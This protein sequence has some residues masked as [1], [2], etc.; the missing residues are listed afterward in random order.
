[1]SRTDA[2]HSQGVQKGDHNKQTNFYLAPSL[3]GGSRVYVSSDFS[4]GPELVGRA[5]ELAVLTDAFADDPSRPTVRVL[6][7]ERGVGKSALALAHGRRHQER[8]G[9]VLWVDAREVSQVAEQCR[10]LLNV[11]APGQ[12]AVDNPV[13]VLHGHLA[14]QGKRW[15]LI[16]DDVRHPNM[17]RGLVPAAG[18]GDVIVTSAATGWRDH[19][20]IDVEPLAVQAGINLLL[21]TVETLTEPAA[22][23]LVA[24]L[25]GSPGV[26]IRAG[27]ALATNTAVDWADYLRLHARG[28]VDGYAT[29]A[30]DAAQ[31]MARAR[32]GSVA[33]GSL[34]DGHQELFAVD[35]DHRLVRRWN[36]LQLPFGPTASSGWSQ[37][38][39]MDEPEP[40]HRIACS[41]LHAGHLEVFAITGDQGLI[42][43]WREGRP[44]RWSA[45]RVLATPG[46]ITGVAAGS[47][48]D[49]C[50]DL[51]VA[52]TDGQV[53]TRGF[54]DRDRR[55]WS[56]WKNFEAPE[57]VAGVVWSG[58]DRPRGHRE[59]F[60]VTK[61][62]RVL[63]RWSHLD[64]RGDWSGWEDMDAPSSVRTATAGSPRQAQQD[65]V[66]V[67]EDGTVFARRYGHT[68]KDW[69]PGWTTMSAHEPIVAITSSSL[70]TGHLE[71]F[72]TT[73]RGALLHRWYWAGAGWT[74]WE[75]FEWA[76]KAP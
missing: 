21:R 1:M 34:R 20:T 45:W 26:L 63:H 33:A 61:A 69:D 56:E 36:D 13:D 41:S 72:A 67:L 75:P 35:R 30:A 18:P 59:L 7:G 66:V 52:T 44:A 12:A 22:R 64:S 23:A 43:R 70:A 5:G 51:F 14:N 68:G 42:H 32:R 25:G 55:D 11:L 47:A 29:S 3:G 9:L 58:M 19:V 53:F 28:Q 6:T 39:P 49:G 38:W 60:A 31:V 62:G 10:K 24:F 17:V 50:Q 8:Y 54:P 46:K 57:P 2:G 71:L 37:W 65:L 40:V 74:E 48:W 73:D 27:E 16:L 76:P 15:L 4:W